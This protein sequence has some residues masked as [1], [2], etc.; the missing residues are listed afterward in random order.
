MVSGRNEF[1]RPCDPAAFSTVAAAGI[2]P[3]GHTFVGNRKVIITPCNPVGIR[4]MVRRVSRC[5]RSGCNGLRP[6]A[7]IHTDRF[8]HLAQQALQN[9]NGIRAGIDVHIKHAGMQH[10]WQFRN[11]RGVIVMFQENFGR[12]IF[13]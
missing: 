3:A 11:A 2:F 4:Q 8:A 7:A 1:F 6:Y 10:W 13:V 12:L 9:F 5:R